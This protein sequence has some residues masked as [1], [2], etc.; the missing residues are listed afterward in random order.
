MSASIPDF[1]PGSRLASASLDTIKPA[2]AAVEIAAQAARSTAEQAQATT[3][4]NRSTN[5]MAQASNAQRLAA[6]E[7]SVASLTSGQTDIHTSV[8]SLATGQTDIQASLTSINAQLTALGTVT[9]PN[10]PTSIHQTAITTTSITVAGT[11]PVAGSPPASYQ[12]FYRTPQ[13]SGAWIPGPTGPTPS[14]VITGLTAS[15]AGTP[16]DVT[17]AGVNSAGIGAQGTSAPVTTTGTGVITVPQAPTAIHSTG[18]TTTSISA[19]LTAPAAGSPPTGGYQWY[20][21]TPGGLGPWT[22]GPVSAGLTVTITGL[23]P[24][25]G[26]TP[27]DVTA[28]GINSAGVGAQGTL[29]NVSTTA[30]G[31]VTSADGTMMP[32]T[33]PLIDKYGAS[34]TI[35]GG[36]LQRNA[37]ADTNTSNVTLGVVDSGGI[38]FQQ[39][40]A[41][42][43]FFD[44]PTQ[45]F[46]WFVTTSPPSQVAP[47]PPPVIG[48]FTIG[49]A[50]ATPTD[51]SI[52]VNLTSPTGFTLAGELFGVA[53]STSSGSWANSFGNAGWVT[54]MGQLDVRG[55]RLQ[56]ED[57]LARIF[58]SISVTTGANFAPIEP[59]VANMNRAFPN[60][61]RTVTIVDP[62][63]TAYAGVSPAIAANQVGQL[64]DYL[65]S[66][67]VHIH[68]WDMYN[69]P[70]GAGSIHA[71]SAQCRDVGS[72]VFTTLASR[73]RGYKFGS[74]PTTAPIIGPYPNDAVS[75]YPALDYL[76]GHWYAG[77][78]DRGEAGQIT[79]DL[80]LSTDPWWVTNVLAGETIGAKK[81]PF[82]L[83][84]YAMG[85]GGGGVLGPESTNMAASTMYAG[86]LAFGGRQNIFQATHVWDG[87]QAVYGW[88][89]NASTMAPHCF[90][91]A[92]CGQVMPGN[93]V[94]ANNALGLI[95]LATTGGLLVV[96]TST[97]VAQNAKKVSIGG[98]A[99]TTLHRWQQSA[100]DSNGGFSNRTGT[101]TTIAAAELASQSFPALSVTVYSP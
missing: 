82:Q 93:V 60:A 90:M 96:N 38:F 91:F 68:N 19:A 79:N 46:P 36:V 9:V 78:R 34:W 17:L 10:A 75:G 94:A 98:L 66:R 81:Y 48:G 32:P 28:A 86:L 92:R 20:Y 70:D 56:G 39:N 52:N 30:V 41:G 89:G 33:S 67:G 85:Y 45:P 69:E 61:I 35:I 64:A 42:N 97:T 5:D 101:T 84:E 23:T 26:G 71:T 88:T 50:V 59:W 8:A 11:A 72:A 100:T 49:A 3:D 95:V 16:Y 14:I 22:T 21:R 1:V 27:Y 73:N 13:G 83:T 77:A 87:A 76:S 53:Q 54:A 6:L 40:A 4:I 99:N 18:T 15:P 63:F 7:A 37:V 25:V 29:F 12:A 44:D 57:V 65:E 62:A 43:W 55:W 24:S 2:V 80:F 58:P 31:T 51:G 74:S 47:P